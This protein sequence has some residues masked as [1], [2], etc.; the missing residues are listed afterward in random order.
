MKSDESIK[1]R[2]PLLKTLYSRFLVNLVAIVVF[3]MVVLGFLFSYMYSRQY[4]SDLKETMIRETNEIN[5]IMQEKWND[6]EKQVI[7]E[8][9]IKIIARKYG[10]SIWIADRSGG[11][12]RY[13]DAEN[14]A[15][16]D[17]QDI[18]AQLPD[19][20]QTILSGE[21]IRTTGFFGD[22][23]KEPVMTMGRPLVLDGY[24]EGVILMH[25]KMSGLVSALQEIYTNVITSAMIAIALAIVLSSI[26]AHRFTKPL[27]EMNRIAKSYAKGDLSQRVEVRSADEIGQLGAS[28][29]SMAKELEGLEDMRRSFVANVSHELKSP[30]ASMRGFVQAVLDGSVPKESEAEYLNIV[31]EETVRLNGLIND[32]L[33]LSKI[34]SGEF[35]LYKTVFD[36]NELIARTLFTFESRIEEKKLNIDLKFKNKPCV[37]I[38]DQDRITQVVR[39]LVDNA[40]KFL[41]PGGQL[42]I[43]THVSTPRKLA[44]VTIKDTGKGISQ[45][46]IE[47]IWERFYKTDKAH[48]PGSEGTG[49]G[50]S[51]VKKIVE[52]HGEN[53]YVKSKPD[54][55]TSFCFTLPLAMD[56]MISVTAKRQAKPSRKSFSA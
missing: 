31:L 19:Y 17:G 28:F 10:A 40:I 44:F 8:E 53:I 16:W 24:V 7:A 35:P 29:N 50:L 56:A 2:K 37:V 43:I 39:N 38:A 3:S 6:K 15:D 52:Q 45:E 30:L 33:D 23:F 5:R 11:M 51:I 46:D 9:E 49:L 48:T 34:E 36:A 21:I 47:H 4:D 12:K 1:K 55:G 14:T 32:L 41:S 20:Y 42:T 18:A 25:V 13:V 27:V 54:C 22:F 26:M